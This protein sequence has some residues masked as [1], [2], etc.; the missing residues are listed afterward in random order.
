MYKHVVFIQG[1]YWDYKTKTVKP[2]YTFKI[3]SKLSDTSHTTKIQEALRQ[4]HDANE[5]DFGLHFFQ[6]PENSWDAIVKYDSYFSE[7]TYYTDINQFINTLKNIR[8]D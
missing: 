1:D 7:T 5:K 2:K 3:S 4:C 6:L 8:K